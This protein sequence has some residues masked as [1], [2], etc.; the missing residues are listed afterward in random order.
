MVW[1]AV[2]NI[3]HK[4]GGPWQLLWG[5]GST[6]VSGFPTEASTYIG[7]Q[8]LLT[9]FKLEL[10]FFK[11]SQKYP[12]GEGGGG[13]LVITQEDYTFSLNSI[14]QCHSKL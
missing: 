6:H 7:L 11:Y 1:S 4:G 2:C 14:A 8:N 3:Q 10:K 12:K 9:D 5:S 13:E